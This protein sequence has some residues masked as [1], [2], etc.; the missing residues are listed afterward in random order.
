[1]LSGPS[2]G[3][4]AGDQRYWWRGPHQDAGGASQNALKTFKS[5]TVRLD[6]GLP[7]T[8]TDQSSNRSASCD[9]RAEVELPGAADVDALDHR[10]HEGEMALCRNR[11]CGF[12]GAAT[13]VTTF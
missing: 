13:R 3:R 6:M 4:Q 9:R 8:S 11:R 5:S 7:S 1:M 12:D 10:A 2:S